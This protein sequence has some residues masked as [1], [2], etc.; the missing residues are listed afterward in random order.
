MGKT[1]LAGTQA[2][3]FSWS[4]PVKAKNGNISLF[5]VSGARVKT[6][7]ITSPNGNV[8]IDISSGKLARGI[9]FA[10]LSYGACEKTINF[11]VCR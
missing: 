2:I 8:S 10:K 3:D 4:L 11:I 5:S 9:Y 7:P 1:R 6:V